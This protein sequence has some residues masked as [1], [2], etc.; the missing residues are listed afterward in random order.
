MARGERRLVQSQ[1]G[2]HIIEVIDPPEVRPLASSDLLQTR[3]GQQAFV[4][5]FLPFV[6]QLRTQAEQTR[7]IKI[8]VP[9][10]SL[11]TQPGQ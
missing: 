4:E 7:Q 6:D 8:L 10:E 1:F 3:A 9:A 5:E 2:W 11:V